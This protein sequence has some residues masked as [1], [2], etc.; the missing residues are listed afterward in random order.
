MGLIL[1]FG[2]PI[3]L[4]VVTILCAR[5]R[6]RAA[7]IVGT[8]FS[9]LLLI[10][11]FPIGFG[12]ADTWGDP[13]WD[14]ARVWLKITFLTCFIGPI[15][16]WTLVAMDKPRLAIAAVLISPVAMLS[17]PLLA[18]LFPIISTASH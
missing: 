6:T 16:A 10:P 13:A 7:L 15:L 11:L 4:I 8:I 2:G 9:L 12:I 18:Y 1:F 3:A 5:Y 14:G 17:G